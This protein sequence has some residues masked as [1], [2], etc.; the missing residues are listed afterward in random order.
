MSISPTRISD[1]ANELQAALTSARLENE[2][3]VERTRQAEERAVVAEK[4]LQEI[5]GKLSILESLK[6][7]E[8]QNVVT[9][10]FE[11]PSRRA[12]TLTFIVAVLS[13]FIGLVSAWL[14][15]KS[16]TQEIHSMEEKIHEIDE[17]VAG[18]REEARWSSKTLAPGTPVTATVSANNN[19]YFRISV[20]P[21]MPALQVS[22]ESLAGDARVYVRYG[23]LP[24]EI[25]RSYRASGGRRWARART[26]DQ[27]HSE[28]IGSL[29]YQCTVSA[30]PS[31]DWFIRVYGQDGP[32]KFRLATRW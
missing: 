24:E 3:L 9:E 8:Y 27:C 23:Q 13:I 2:Q 1:L 10:L 6:T 19:E 32:A 20:P 4:R 26:L 31:G 25:D 14:S 5:Q 15:G 30:P 17:G 16:V 12:A 21:G 28:Y 22:F 11:G 7:K 18:I 29:M